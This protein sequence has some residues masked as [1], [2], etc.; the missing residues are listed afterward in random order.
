MLYTIK[1]A[2]DK[3]GLSEHTIRY[4]DREGLL[5]LLKRTKNGVRK[6]SDSDMEWLCLICCLKSSGMSIEQIKDFMN[7]CLQ[8]EQTCEDRKEILVEH[9]DHILN[10]IESL[11]NSLRTVNY[12]IEHYKEIG[13]FHIDRQE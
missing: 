4:Y 3:T 8:G 5:P 11:Q 1:E 13:L 7:L 10:Q 2:V 6:F 12:K 9:R